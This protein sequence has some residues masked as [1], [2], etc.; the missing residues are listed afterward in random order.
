LVFAVVVLL[1]PLLAI[2]AV[3][4]PLLDQLLLLEQQQ[5]AC[6]VGPASCS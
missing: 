5:L 1:L 6:S 2:V 3:L 4:L